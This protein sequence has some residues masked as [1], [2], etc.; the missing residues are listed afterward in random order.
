MDEYFEFK[1]KHHKGIDKKMLFVEYKLED[2]ST[3]TELTRKLVDTYN[4][5]VKEHNDL[6]VVIDLRNIETFSKKS[7]WEGAG[8]LKEYEQF[9]LDHI[10]KGYII[11]ESTS[12]NMLINTILKVM[13]NS[14]PTLLVKDINE[15]LRDLA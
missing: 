11:T 8:I 9:Y 2:F 5:K 12:A 15:I 13:N 1:I 10:T 4:E 14:I 3:D 6:I 7:V